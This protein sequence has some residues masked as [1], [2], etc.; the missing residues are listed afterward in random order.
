MNFKMKMK[1]GLRNINRTIL[2]LR[3]AFMTPTVLARLERPH[4]LVRQGDLLIEDGA[5]TEGAR[6]FFV[7]NFYLSHAKA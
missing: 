2:P 7:L 6:Y 4:R 3:M 5:L 1:I